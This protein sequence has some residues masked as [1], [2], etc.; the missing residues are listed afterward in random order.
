MAACAYCGLDIEQ[1]DGQWTHAT[2]GR[3]AC[4][5]R[6]GITGPRATP[7]KTS[8]TASKYRPDCPLCRAKTKE[9]Q[10]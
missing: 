3:P 4:Y 1:R 8:V 6:H 5:A 7:A 9:P 2:S 10:P